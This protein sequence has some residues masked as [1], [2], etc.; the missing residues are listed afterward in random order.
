MHAGD[1]RPEAAEQPLPSLKP[2]T[3]AK[4]IDAH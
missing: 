1:C 2:K 3:A 4:P